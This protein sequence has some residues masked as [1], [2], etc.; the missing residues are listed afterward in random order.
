MKIIDSSNLFAYRVLS[1]PTQDLIIT[2][3]KHVLI[4][5]MN[6]RYR[7]SI[8]C[9]NNFARFGNFHINYF[10]NPRNENGV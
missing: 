6:Y 1:L 10:A 9:T 5:P 8:L 7:L 3:R 4:K 2:I